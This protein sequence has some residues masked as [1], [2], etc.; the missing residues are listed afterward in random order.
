MAGS[1]RADFGS[2]KVAVLARKQALMREIVYP[3]VSGFVDHDH[4]VDPRPAVI[5]LG[6]K[7]L[8]ADCK[9]AVA[10]DP[11]IPDY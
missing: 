6:A 3:G 4:R 9:P 2:S 8:D 7:K 10:G 5:E 1:L 11:Y